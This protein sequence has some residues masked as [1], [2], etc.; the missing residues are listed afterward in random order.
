MVAPW[1]REIDAR[2]GFYRLPLCVSAGFSASVSAKMR[3]SERGW[4]KSRGEE[5]VTWNKSNRFV[6]LKASRDFLHRL[7]VSRKRIM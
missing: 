1:C 6:S 2:C 4:R 5:K 3:M 7:F